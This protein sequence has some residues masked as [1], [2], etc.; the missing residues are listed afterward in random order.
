M[1]LWLV[2]LGKLHF[3]FLRQVV[4]DC[5][6]TRAEYRT[7]FPSSGLRRFAHLRRSVTQCNT[8][9]VAGIHTR[10]AE[11]LILNQGESRRN[12]M[13]FTMVV[14]Q[15]LAPLGCCDG[16]LYFSC[17]AFA[18]PPPSP[19]PTTRTVVQ[20]QKKEKLVA[21]HRRA[22]RPGQARMFAWEGRSIHP[23]A[24]RSIS[25]GSSPSPIGNKK[26]RL[27]LSAFDHARAR[28]RAEV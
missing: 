22:R 20:R 7:F 6:A 2:G 3:T 21:S 1:A 13:P 24:T 14:R 15:A 5:R 23:F 27:S 12:W 9:A 28:V 18:S 26:Q 11:R 10:E 4:R 8:K 16:L 17:Y 25:P 19:F